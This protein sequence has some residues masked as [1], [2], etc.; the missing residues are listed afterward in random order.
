MYKI[1]HSKL[2]LKCDCVWNSGA[3]NKNFIPFGL[4]CKFVLLKIEQLKNKM[5]DYEKTFEFVNYISLILM[6]QLEYPQI[7]FNL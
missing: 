4:D 1:H 3:Y 2:N 6:S 5:K 7:E